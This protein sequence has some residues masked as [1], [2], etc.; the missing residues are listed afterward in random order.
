MQYESILNSKQNLLILKKSGCVKELIHVI[1]FQMVSG[2]KQF[3][4]TLLSL[5]RENHGLSNA[6]A[7]LQYIREASSAE[8]SPLTHNAHLYRLK[9]KKQEPGHGSVWLAICAKGIEIYEVCVCVREDGRVY[10]IHSLCLF[11]EVSCC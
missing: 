11:N 7:E 1:Y 3:M 6:E 10:I 9:H 5:H 8:V 2:D 4:Q